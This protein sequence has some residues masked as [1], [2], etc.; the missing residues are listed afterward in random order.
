MVDDEQSVLDA[1]RR[2]LRAQRDVWAVTYVDSGRAAW[3]RLLS[4]EFDLLVCDVSM[5]GMDGL[6][7][8]K[9]T[10]RIEKTRD[11][12]VVMLTGVA[13]RTLK[14]R[15][16]DAGAADLLNKP[17]EP[18]DLLARLRNAIR[19]KAYQDELRARRTTRWKGPS[20]SGPRSCPIPGSTSSG[21]WPRRPSTE[22]L[23]WGTT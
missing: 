4:K 3:Q 19:L 14:R 9:Q 6:E 21:D 16:L 17:V 5:P 18:E 20:R 8:L 1:L 11:I 7:L 10:Q 12:P 22:T 23:R 2:M 15:A 13:D